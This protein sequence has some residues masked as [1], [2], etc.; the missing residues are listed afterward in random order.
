MVTEKKIRSWHLLQTLLQ[1]LL[2]IFSLIYSLFIHA[3][4]ITTFKAFVLIILISLQFSVLNKNVNSKLIQCNYYFQA[5]SITSTPIFFFTFVNDLSIKYTN[6]TITTFVLCLITIYK[7]FMFIPMGE[8][9]MGNVQNKW[10]RFCL[11]WFI[12]LIIEIES[13]YPIPTNPFLK[14]C[15]NSAIIGSLSFVVTTWFV[16]KKWG[17]LT[18]NFKFSSRVSKVILSILIIFIVIDCLFNGFN[19][20]NSLNGILTNWNFRVASNS[21]LLYLTLNAF[22]AGIGEEWM[23]RF[24]ILSFLLKL[25]QNSSR[26]I[27]WAIF[28]DGLIFGLIHF[29]NTPVQPLSATILQ[30]INAMVG[31][32]LFSTL[33][34]YTGTIISNIAYHFLYDLAGMIA[35][36][37]TSMLSP[38]IFDW[39]LLIFI[40][41]IY[42]G[43]ALFLVTGKRKKVVEYNLNLQGL[44]KKAF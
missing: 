26:Q 37:S 9:A 2:V 4:G 32:I 10:G 43:L 24:C 36:G 17:F 6:D 27:F 14:A 28:L 19:D 1:L 16:M 31:G 22:A 11:L 20:A 7:I 33:Y 13:T 44:N 30:V 42:L 41:L 35:S 25:L 12:Y 40:V 15:T 34:L 18:P 38:T 5:I 3:G 39:Q 23:M 29:L 8:L 21:N